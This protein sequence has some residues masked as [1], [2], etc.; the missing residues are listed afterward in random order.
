MAG[1]EGRGGG[2]LR[3]EGE[4]GRGAGGRTPA[5][6]GEGEPERRGDGANTD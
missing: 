6:G 5:E 2:A 3:V 4:S 1:V